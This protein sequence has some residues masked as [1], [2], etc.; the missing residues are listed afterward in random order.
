MTRLLKRVLPAV[1]YQSHHT[2]QI[3][4]LGYIERV[5]KIKIEVTLPPSE[6]SDMF[7][8]LNS[9]H[10]GGVGLIDHFNLTTCKYFVPLKN[11]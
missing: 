5:M 3:N 9:G 1:Y 11:D 6:V 8:F 7:C 4:Q 2:W 10:L